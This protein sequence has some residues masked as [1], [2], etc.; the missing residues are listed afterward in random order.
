MEPSHAESPAVHGRLVGPGRRRRQAYSGQG[1]RGIEV[2]GSLEF[3]HGRRVA[4]PAVRLPAVQVRLQRGQPRGRGD[5]EPLVGRAGL[6]HQEPR[7]ELV[8]QLREAVDRSLDCRPSAGLPLPRAEH[9]GGEHH[10]PACRARDLSGEDSAGPESAGRAQ[11]GA[12][13]E[14]AVHRATGRAPRGD[15]GA[16]IHRPGAPLPREPGREQVDH[17]FPHEPQSRVSRRDTERKHRDQIR[18]EIRG[19]AWPRDPG[20]EDRGHEDRCD[21]GSRRGSPV[22]LAFRKLSRRRR[23]RRLVEWEWLDGGWCRQWGR[24]WGRRRL[25][26]RARARGR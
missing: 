10:Q 11:R 2:H 19:G 24:R 14:L 18:I 26:C 16:G 9:R 20:G 5:R 13:A 6:Q 12:P 21:S 8:D 25:R 4:A 17:A 1:E 22:R 7:G 3:P 15:R 23:W